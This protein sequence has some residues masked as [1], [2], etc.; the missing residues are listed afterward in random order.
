VSDFHDLEVY[1]RAYQMSLQL[2]RWLRGRADEVA[3]QLRR[4]SKSIPANIAEG[5]SK[6]NTATEAKRF[7]SIALR[8]LDEVK[9]WLEYCRDLNLLSEQRVGQATQEYREIGAMLYTLWQ[10]W[11]SMRK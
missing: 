11:R 4:A 2:H 10:R 3:G 5:C 6:A 1:R 8:S 9:V 7:L